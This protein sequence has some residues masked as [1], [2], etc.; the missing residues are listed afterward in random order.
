[1]RIELKETGKGEENVNK[2]KR[3]MSGGLTVFRPL[4]SRCIGRICLLRTV[5]MS[6]ISAAESGGSNCLQ[7]QEY[8]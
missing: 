3:G 6:S 2:V 7:K 8:F 1:M 5:P 4:F